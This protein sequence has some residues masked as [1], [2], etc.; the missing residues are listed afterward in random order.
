MLKLRLW[1]GV[2][3]WW[4]FIFYNIERI[5]EPINIASF[6]YV[7]VPVAA[8]AVMLAPQMFRKLRLILLIA[9][10][11]IVYFILKLLFNYQLV[12]PALPLT[13]MEIVCIL[14]TLFLV[15]QVG[16]VVWDFEDTIANITFRQVGLPPRLYETTT[17][18]DL[19]RE[20]KRS[21][22]FRHPLSLVVIRSDFDP[23]SVRL[24]RILLEFQQTLATRYL[25]AR[26]ARMLS[27]ELRDYD[28]IAW[29]RDSF[30]VLL[31][32]TTPE[33][34]SRVAQRISKQAEK[35]L[36]LR[37]KMGIAGF[38]EEAVTLTGLID[39]ASSKLNRQAAQEMEPT[40]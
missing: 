14:V 38:P 16:Y 1:L 6:V 18:E 4:L 27:E 40:P 20:V 37:L 7:L 29:E 24:N 2:L 39:A 15:R 26:L 17:T 33:D 30:V 10:T 23:E 28:L 35:A 3:V 12:G 34:A 13:I 11:L 9:P 31:P 22:R 8:G 32:E 5:N 36:S 19:Y 25:Q 21:R